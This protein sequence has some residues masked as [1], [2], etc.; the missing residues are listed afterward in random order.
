MEALNSS[1]VN[2]SFFDGQIVNNEL[3]VFFN[4]EF[5]FTPVL[6]LWVFLHWLGDITASPE[7]ESELLQLRLVAVDAKDSKGV[8][9]KL[10][11]HTLD[12]PV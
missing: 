1:T 10:L 2:F 6:E 7:Q 9:S 8:T 11:V 12:E 3:L 4:V 5:S